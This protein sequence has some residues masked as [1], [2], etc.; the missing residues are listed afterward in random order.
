MEVITLDELLGVMPEHAVVD[1]TDDAELGSIDEGNLDQAEQSAIRDLDLYASRYYAL[2]L[3]PVDAVRELVRQL[4]K[5]H[6]YFRRSAYP[7]EIMELYKQLQKKMQ[8]LTPLSL[9]IPGVEPEAGTENAGI[10]VSAPAQ[11][12]HDNFTG[13]NG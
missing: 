3:P 4:T 6:L 10:S 1:L 2:P 12:F 13:V 7:E 11:R 5:C 8:N 9:G